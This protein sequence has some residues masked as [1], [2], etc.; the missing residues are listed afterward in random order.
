[1]PHNQNLGFCYRRSRLTVVTF[2]GINRNTSY[3]NILW[4]I[5]SFLVDM[6]ARYQARKERD[7]R[8][9]RTGGGR[10]RGGGRGGGGRR[11]DTM[12]SSF[13]W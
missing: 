11:N 12:G 6:A 1:M 2:F 9:G 7:E 13:G 3:S 10:G 5:F 8:E 4:P